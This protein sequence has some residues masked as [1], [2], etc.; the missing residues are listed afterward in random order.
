MDERDNREQREAEAYEFK[1]NISINSFMS[2]P[3]LAL[4]YYDAIYFL[5]Y[6]CISA[7]LI[8]YKVEKYVMPTYAIDTEVVTLILFALSQYL[9][10]NIGQ[11]A[12]AEKEP[13]KVLFY[14]ITTFFI[15]L[16]YV[17][18]IRLQT[19]VLLADFI[20]SWVGIGFTI[21]EF[22]SAIWLLL[23][24]RRKKKG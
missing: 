23:I 1:K 16:L 2:I 8:V 14:L 3:F 9:R 24:F 11:A 5:L 19:Y 21:A 10:Y 7:G 17:F 4:N 22:A 15:A 20:L 13:R 6:F 12:V 18:Q